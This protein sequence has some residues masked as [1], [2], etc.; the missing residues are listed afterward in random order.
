[1]KAVEASFIKFS[2]N[3]PQFAISIYQRTYSWLERECSQ[4]WNVIIRTGSRDKISAPRLLPNSL[5]VLQFPR[6]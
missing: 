2:Q 5:Y 1:M 3:S 6:I 4:L